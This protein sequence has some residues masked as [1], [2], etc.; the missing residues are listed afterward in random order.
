MSALEGF[1]LAQAG[2]QYAKDPKTPA[3][4]KQVEQD[5]IGETYAYSLTP[6]GSPPPTFKFTRIGDLVAAAPQWLIRGLLEAGSFAS[7]YGQSGSMKSFFA[8]D[9][10]LCIATGRP[11]HGRSIA[12][13]GLVVYIAG[14]GHAGLARRI[15]A[16]SI[17]NNVDTSRA[18]II[19]SH[20]AATLCEPETM[21][22]VAYSIAYTARDYG[23]GVPRLI[24]LDTWSRNIGGDEN[25]SLDAAAAVA[26]VDA[27]CKPYGAASFVVHHEGVAAGRARGSTVL[28][29]ACENELRCDL[30]R[31]GVLRV[32][33]TKNKDSGLENPI[34][35]QIRD[36]DLPGIFDDDGYPV[37]SAVLDEIEYGPEGEAKTPGGRNQVKA[38][39]ILEALIERHRENLQASG[40]AQSQA[41]VSLADWRDACKIQGIDKRRFSEVQK[42]MIAADTISIEGVHVSIRS[43]TGPKK[44]EIVRNT[45]NPASSKGPKKSGSYII[46]PD[47]GPL[48]DASNDT[49]PE[50]MGKHKQDASPPLDA[51][52]S[53]ILE[54][55]PEPPTVDYDD[56][57]AP[58]GAFGENPEYCEP[59]KEP[60]L[61]SNLC[62]LEQV[63]EAMRLLEEAEQRRKAKALERSGAPALPTIETLEA[64]LSTATGSERGDLLFQIEKLRQG[65]PLAAA[66]EDPP[67]DLF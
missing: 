10:A 57:D 17:A 23:Y 8:L 14:E 27:I 52:P 45:G 58:S 29:S 43:E 3:Q 50:G 5:T 6:E 31:D 2:Y 67:L 65:M 21:K 66:L 44:S 36:V 4:L 48:S 39:E 19:V 30:G 25:S 16:W 1:T 9:A 64:R 62:N 59:S 13:Q 32:T 49:D 61:Q 41:R 7:L 18:P 63:P 60:E 28:R 24:V 37:H 54:P 22:A 40:H 26:A 56:D 20:T 38:L 42:S 34:A 55:E 53:P 46:G 35:F 12:R 51:I 11:F 33:P 15:Q 47:F